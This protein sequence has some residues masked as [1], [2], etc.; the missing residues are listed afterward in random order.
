LESEI[1]PDADI[2]HITILNE[3]ASVDGGH[4][5]FNIDVIMK[6]FISYA[7]G[8]MFGRYSLDQ[9]GLILA[10]AGETLE[11]YLR[12]VPEPSFVPDE[13]N[14]IP[15]LEGEW[16]S[17]DIVE[18]FKQFL[19]VTLG[20]EHYEENLAFLEGAIGKDI[21]TYFVRDFY[22]EHVKMYKKRPIYWLFSSPNSS[23]NALIYMHRYRPDTVSVILNNYLRQYREKLNAHKPHQEAIA[24]NPSASQS[25]K[26]KALKEADWVNKILSELKEYEDEI[27]YPLA[28]QQV[29]I[30]LDDGVKVNYNKFGNALK[31]ITGLSE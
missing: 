2:K 4:L 1:E 14:V 9:P 22:N 16:F 5:D 20:T 15:I 25:E 3:V 17:D 24:R 6:E 23:F 28:A 31:K 8:C 21:R 13:D 10:N 7:V 26:T 19:K 18:R 11:D 12:Q 27:L 29:K 30:D